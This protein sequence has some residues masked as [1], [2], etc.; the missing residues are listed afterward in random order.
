MDLRWND[1]MSLGVESMDATHREFLLLL[2]S[3]AEAEPAAF[4][5]RLDALLEHTRAH[6]AAE[7]ALMAATMFSA[8]NEHKGEHIR[9]LSELAH[10]RAKLASGRAALLHAYVREQLPEWFLLHLQTMDA[11][12][13][14]HVRRVRQT[15]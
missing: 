3:V 10:L 1:G 5:A 6:F 4:G 13:A 11:V 2:A 14:A 12:T 15:S 9:V 7:E 8:I